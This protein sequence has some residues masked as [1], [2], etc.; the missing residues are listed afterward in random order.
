[1]RNELEML[2][3]LRCFHCMSDTWQ[4]QA[5]YPGLHHPC[6]CQLCDRGIG[7]VALRQ[8]TAALATSGCQCSLRTM[9]ASHYLLAE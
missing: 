9:G 1:M 4:S 5:G 2:G 3:G 6:T 7:Q 8:I